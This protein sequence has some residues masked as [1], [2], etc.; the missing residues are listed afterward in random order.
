MKK[1]T[2]NR[3]QRT[4]KIPKNKNK[5]IPT[6]KEKKQY[7]DINILNTNAR[8][9][10]PKIH[11]LID[12]YDE[13]DLTF[14]VVTETWLAD[15]ITL[16]EDKQDLLLGAGLSIICR[17]RK[18]DLRGNAYR[19]VALV[20]REELCNFKSLQLD[21]PSNF[22]ILTAVGSAHSLTRKIAVVGCYVPP[23]YTV[24]RAQAC[25]NHIEGV[26]IELKRRLKDPVIIVMGDFNQ[27]E[28]ETALQEFWD[29]GGSSAGPTRGSLKL[30]RIFTNLGQIKEVKILAPLSTSSDTGSVKESDHKVVYLSASIERKERYKRLSYSYRYNNPDSERK[31]GE[32]IVQKD[33]SELLQ[34]PN[35]T[36][37]TEAYQAEIT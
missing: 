34:L 22:E 16:E 1:R 31:F 35:S 25:L 19:G 23:N 9:L 13:L 21:N 7:I 32:W 28:V 37:N 33:W 20:Y 36:A 14:G 29:M 11:S 3:T 8:S 10:C 5:R 2:V 12:M 30:D 26:V 4:Q 27:W 6:V 17:N 18:P 24:A 15:G